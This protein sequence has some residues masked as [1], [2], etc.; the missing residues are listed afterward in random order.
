[1]K[2]KHHVPH[3][4]TISKLLR[5]INSNNQRVIISFCLREKVTDR[6]DKTSGFLDNS[7]NSEMANCRSVISKGCWF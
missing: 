5:K 6:E 4:K 1:M 3:Q 2:S 7:F